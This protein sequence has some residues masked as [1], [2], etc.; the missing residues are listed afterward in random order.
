[1]SRFIP[2]LKK[3]T[4]IFTLTVL[5]VLVI[6]FSFNKVMSYTSSDRYCMVCHYHPHAEVDWKLS[7]H[8]SNR[9]G[10]VVHCTECHLPP[11]ENTLN[12]TWA[13]AKH[14]FKDVYGYLTKEAD[15]I[16][17]KAKRLPEKAR[18][19]VYQESC[20]KCHKNLY[21][22]TL[23]DKGSEAHLNY[24]KNPNGRVC[25]TCHIDVG[26]YDPAAHSHNLE[27]GFADNS[28]KKIFTEPTSVSELIS[29]TEQIPGTAV[30]FNM[31]AIKGGTFKMGGSPGDPYISKN[32]LPQ[33]EVE[34]KS[35]FMAEIEVS[36]DEY[37]AFFNATGS[38]GRKEAEVVNTDQVDAIS[39]AT[40]PWGAPD[41]GWGKGPRPAITMTHHAA[42]T[43]CRW[44]SQVTGKAYRLP[45]E[46]EW[47]YAARGGTNTAYFFAGD[48]KK[49]ER[50]GFFRK[51][52]GPDTTV[53]NSFVV[54]QENSPDR[55]Q[56]P[57]FVQ[58]NP[59]GLKNMLG[60]VA[61]FCLDVYDP[62]VYGKYP[63]GPI[64]NPRGP[65]TGE[66][67][68]I[69]GGSFLNGAS[70]VRVSGRDYTRTKDW[71]VTDPQIP[72]SI[73]WY[74]DCKHVG[75]RVVCEFDEKTGNKE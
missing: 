17:W 14:G 15:E 27:F 56:E 42:V 71:L 35:F 62:E 52:F 30:A 38:Q 63:S 39:G 67:H 31:K 37:L 59:F 65:R 25:I 54:Y 26:H 9:T 21:P 33:R 41:Q 11:K 2:Y 40:P 51:L 5:L 22:T 3:P 70:G 73:W 58:P 24:E 68:V 43:Y 45:T 19:F 20:V 4:T 64:K 53:I 44:L 75:F 23:S 32:E 28:N 48:P 57:S 13:K 66:E 72:K 69:R 10:V 47:E 7:A 16:D 1:M 50:D 6:L 18:H 49:F 55:T 12:Y 61:E 60:N 46:A 74:S 34:V 29:F 36:W 8:S